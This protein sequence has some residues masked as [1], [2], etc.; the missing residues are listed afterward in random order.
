MSLQTQ[1]CALIGTSCFFFGIFGILFHGPSQFYLHL[2]N[3]RCHQLPVGRVS[4][5]LHCSAHIDKFSAVVHFHS[6]AVS[7]FHF[8][9]LIISFVHG[10]VLDPCL[11]PVRFHRSC[12][13]PLSIQNESPRK[14]P[15]KSRFSPLFATSCNNRRLMYC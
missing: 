6:S 3:A 11:D 14:S 4:F 2:R 10:P 9:S 8:F 1:R 12:F 5:L 7:R 15:E 13:P